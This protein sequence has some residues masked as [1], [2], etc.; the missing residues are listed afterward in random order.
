MAKRKFNSEDY[1]AQQI[2]RAQQGGQDYIFALVRRQYSE[3]DI[4]PVGAGDYIGLDKEL[5][6][7]KVT[8]KDPE[9]E[10]FGE[11]IDQPN[12]EPT[13]TRVVFKDKMTPANVKKYQALVG[14]TSYGE[15]NLVYKFKQINITADNVE[16]FWTSKMDDMYDKYVLKNKVVMV[17]KN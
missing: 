15:T 7:R 16:E 11:R 13:G 1:W 4:E 3:D 8:D 10:T 5:S 12:S 9:S 6:Y 17:E 2:I 14:I